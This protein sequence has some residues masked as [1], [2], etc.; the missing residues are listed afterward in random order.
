MCDC[1]ERDV[2]AEQLKM[3]MKADAVDAVKHVQ[4]G[5]KDVETLRKEEW[6]RR[7][8]IRLEQVLV[9]PFESQ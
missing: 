2:K 3:S 9:S 6:K 5:F 4:M 1:Q 7:R 8:L